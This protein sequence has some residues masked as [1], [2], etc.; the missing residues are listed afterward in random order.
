M[1]YKVVEDLKTGRIKTKEEISEPKRY[2]FLIGADEPS[3]TAQKQMIPLLQ[4]SNIVFNDIVEAFSTESVTNEFYLAYRT[5]FE[6]LTLSLVHIKENDPK[7]KEN[8]EKEFIR[9]DDFAKKLLGQIVFIYFIQRK[10]W[11]GIKRDSNGDFGRWGS[12]DRKFLR[13]L[14]NKKYCDYDNFFNDVLEHLLYN[15]LGNENPEDYYSKFNC[16]IPFLGGDIFEPLKVIIGL[17]LIFI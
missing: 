3:F 13:N 10:G 8:F 2:S 9:E 12:G 11:L 7:I 14:F 1:S 5:L 4:S 16:K 17:K 15:G 6:D